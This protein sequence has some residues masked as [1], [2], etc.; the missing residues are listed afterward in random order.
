MS[1]E[2][3]NTSGFERAVA[4]MSRRVA[5]IASV[6]PATVVAGLLADEHFKKRVIDAVSESDTL[7][8]DIINDPRLRERIAQD[9]LDSHPTLIQEIVN[10]LADSTALHHLI[11]EKTLST[12]TFIDAVVHALIS[13]ETFMDNIKQE[14]IDNENLFL[15]IT[16]ALIADDVFLANIAKQIV[17]DAD[18]INH[19]T[20][21][22]LNDSALIQ[23]IA[24]QMIETIANLSM[25]DPDGK[26]VAERDG[27]I[28]TFQA[29]NN[30]QFGIVKGQP[31]NSPETWHRVNFINGMGH[32]NRQALADFID[33]QIKN[34][35]G[36]SGGNGGG[37][38]YQ[39][40]IRILGDLRLFGPDDLP[41]ATNTGGH[42]TLQQATPQ[43]Y[44]VCK[45]RKNSPCFP[46]QMSW[47]TMDGKMAAETK[48]DV[49]MFAPFS[50]PKGMPHRIDLFD[51]CTFIPIGIEHDCKPNGCHRLDPMLNNQ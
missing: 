15:F 19:I 50:F 43:Q 9:I 3:L 13:N 24:N 36:G 18:V 1:N 26:A 22:I 14:I 6:D 51:Q 46:Q 48:N 28:F 40:I 20:Q 11:V 34:A 17:N 16:N 5:E 38:T 39:D 37:I 29:A 27:G 4:R 42:L 12:L 35:G 2:F 33:T 23:N 47:R 7:I 21:A 41:L 10:L 8:L 44:G 49:H 32:I 31:N 25:V 30:D 45:P